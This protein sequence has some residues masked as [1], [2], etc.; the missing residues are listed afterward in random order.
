MPFGQVPVLEANGKIVDQSI[1][2]ARYVA[3]LVKLT[4][5]DPWEDLLIDS[6]VYTI[7]DLR[8]SE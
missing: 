3:K 8:Q 6:I 2:I 7:D 1:A 5:N 4:G